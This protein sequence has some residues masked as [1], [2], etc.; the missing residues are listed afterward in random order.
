MA[1]H[2]RPKETRFST[3]QKKWIKKKFNFTCKQC[4]LRDE[5]NIEVD[6]IVPI[7]VENNNSIK[8][9]AQ[10]LCHDC[11]MQK[12]KEDNIKYKI[13]LDIRIKNGNNK[14]KRKKY[15]KNF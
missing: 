13:I 14:I 8:T 11:H 15:R 9:N 10:L 7:Y 6:H 5:K 12:T 2:R 1:K 4:G 3:I